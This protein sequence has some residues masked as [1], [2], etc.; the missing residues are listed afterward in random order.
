M[1]KPIKPSVIINVILR[2][3]IHYQFSNEKIF[4]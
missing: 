1:L 2:L 3:L 4:I